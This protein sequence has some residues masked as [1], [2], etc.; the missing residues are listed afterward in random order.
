MVEQKI[1]FDDGAGYEQSM[2][3]WSRLAGDI[4]L[5]WLAPPSAL[6][7]TAFHGPTPSERRPAKAATTSSSMRAS[8]P[9]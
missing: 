8:C 5:D 7:N 3:I 1:Q 2:G 4:F 6:R 9:P